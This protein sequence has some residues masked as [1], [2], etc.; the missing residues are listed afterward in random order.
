VGSDLIV[1]AALQL[2]LHERLALRAGQI[3]HR[4]HEVSKLPAPVRDLRR[5]LY[6]VVVLVEVPRGPGGP[7]G[8]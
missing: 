7:A 2:S 8:R 6:S 3:P 1:S 4:G 5:L